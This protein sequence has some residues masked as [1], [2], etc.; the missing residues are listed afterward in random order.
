MVGAAGITWPGWYI[1]AYLSA[2]NVYFTA[3]D[4]PV[5]AFTVK[6]GL[7]VLVPIWLGLLFTLVC[8][9]CPTGL[10]ETDETRSRT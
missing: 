9:G 6:E 4:D 1:I 2:R 5:G 7:F 8:M 3:K 10:D